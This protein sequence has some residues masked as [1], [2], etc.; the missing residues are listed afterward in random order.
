[1]GN[2]VGRDLGCPAQRP[3]INTRYFTFSS[4]SN[5]T[6]IHSKQLS[7]NRNPLEFLHTSTRNLNYHTHT[8]I[9]SSNVLSVRDTNVQIKPTPFLEKDK[10]KS[11]EYHRQV[12]QSRMN[13]EQ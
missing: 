3:V 8:A 1:M 11:M 2:D 10:P 13:T 4:T 9:M 6:N 5:G 12:L 7:D